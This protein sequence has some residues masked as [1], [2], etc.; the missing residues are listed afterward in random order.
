MR[1]LINVRYEALFGKDLRKVMLSECGNGKLGVALQLLALPPD[2]AEA[3]M[4]HRAMRGSGT[5]ERFL[6]PVLCGRDN[7]EMVQLK[8]QYF[9][10]YDKDLAV[11]LAG[12][13][14]G[15][16]ERLMF[17]SLQASEEPF[18]DDY[19]TDEKAEHDAE[20]FRAAGEEKFFGTDEKSL[21][22]IIAKSPPV[23]LEK[24]NKIYVERNERTLISALESELGGDVE[25]G[26]MH[27]VGMKIKPAETVAKLIK[28]SCAG[29]GTDE[30]GLAC[31]IIRYQ[32][33]LKDANEAHQELYSKSIQDRIKDE[34]GGDYE[35]LLCAIVDFA[36]A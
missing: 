30:I 23:Y 15:D 31:D 27:A 17:H 18:D 13:L 28:S 24:I 29:F 22:E 6:W 25:K 5:R 11:H 20:M 16:F 2:E 26:S 36:C 21:F 32:P 9:K 14:R 19:H 10:F 8:E 3:V 7:Q 35:S 1:Y 12:E 33:L 34:V 4:L